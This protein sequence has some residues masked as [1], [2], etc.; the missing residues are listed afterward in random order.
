LPKISRIIE[1]KFPYSPTDDQLNLFRFFDELIEKNLPRHTLLIRGYA[2]TGKTVSIAS[3]V[4]SLPLFN[5]KSLLLAPTGRA[6]KVISSYSGNAAFT[7]HKIIYRNLTDQESGALNF[8]LQK[9]FHRHTVFI[10]D[11]A[12]M[13]PEGKSGE[14]NNVLRDLLEYVFTF[15]TNK[16][17]LIGDDAQ[18]P[19]VGYVISS[20][21]DR[22]NLERNYG[23]SVQ[24]V[25]LTDVV[26]QEKDSGILSRA[27][28]LREKIS[29]REMETNFDLNRDKHSDIRMI[30]S[31][32][33]G[34]VLNEIYQNFNPADAIVICRSNRETVRFNQFIRTNV[35]FRND[36]LEAGDSV[37]IVRNNYFWLPDDSKA[38]F[39]ANGDFAEVLAIKNHEEKYGFRFADL[40][41]R[42]T[43]YPDQEPIEAKTILNPLY[44]DSPSMTKEEFNKLFSVVMKDQNIDTTEKPGKIIRE[45]P[46][47]NAL[48]IKFTYAVTCHKAQ[49]GQW[50]VVL[51]KQGYR[52]QGIAD[53]EYLQWLYTAVTRATEICYFIDFVE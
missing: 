23:L 22:N 15:D 6:A 17:I 2:G 20:S 1:D 40:R 30:S 18:L 45:N 48:Q 10:V 53:K 14:N 43:D 34:E 21:L 7:I 35:L 11:E 12:S 47:L 38:G 32:E 4:K 3:L 9:N 41:L 26:R 29:G 33:L 27:T 50:P 16:L 42:L 36:E 44:S 39:L 46:Y 37:M 31:L 25:S 49:G 13:I 8:E 51:I 52:K 28:L 24:E 5:Y 19:P